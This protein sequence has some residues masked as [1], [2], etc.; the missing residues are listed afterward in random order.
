MTEKIVLFF[1]GA[2]RASDAAEEQDADAQGDDSCE[3]EARGEE[4]V[5]E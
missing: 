1:A 2:A 4:R 3:Q 5:D